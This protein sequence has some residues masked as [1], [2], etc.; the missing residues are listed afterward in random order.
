MTGEHAGGGVIDAGEAGLDDDAADFVVVGSGA[1]GGAAARTLARSGA[2]VIV[3]EEGPAVPAGALGRAVKETMATLFRNQG[4]QTAFGRATIPIL[5]GRCVGGSTFV[6]SAIVWRLPDPVLAAWH[7][8]FGLADG[9]PAAALDAAYARIEEEMS[10]RPVTEDATAGLQDL[11]MRQGAE[12]AGVAGRFLH[13]Y[14]RGCHASGR[15]FHGCPY[16]AK[17]STAVNYLRRAAGDGAV[18]YANARVDRVTV[19]RSRARAVVGSS[20]GGDG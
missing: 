3:L 7:R 4:K 10:V 2:R 1:G 17:Q 16:E 8:D 6:N 18:V 5:Q 11:R 20:R 12:R 9:L 13:R 15:C 19:E 14:E